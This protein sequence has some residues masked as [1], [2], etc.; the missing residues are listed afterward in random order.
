MTNS[1]RSTLRLRLRG[2]SYPD[3]EIPLA[4]LAAIADRAQQLATRLARAE[5]G[6]G[7]P[8]RSPNRLAEGVR[9]MF[10]GIEPGSTQLLIAGPPRDPQFDLG[11]LSEEAIERA[12]AQLVD[13]LDA[14]AAGTPLPAGYDDLSRRGLAEWLE[15]LAQAAPEVEVEGR[16]GARAPKTVRLDPASASAHLREPPAPPAPPP[17]VAVEGVLYAVN[18][19][20]GRYR[21]EDD[22][23]SS[24]DL[25]TSLFTTE[26]VAPLLG[27]RVAAGGAAKYD[28]S[29]KLKEIDAT[30]IAPAPDIPGLDP[31]RFWR[32]VELDELL[33][34]ATPLESIDELT[35]PGLTVEEGDAFLRAIRE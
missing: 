12:F 11:P 15:A 1:E 3:G 9:L 23:G 14:A 10:V 27:Q 35:I 16:V 8:G 22:M 26:Q 25:V 4:N 31:S 24:I 13:G 2:A 30:T 32:N 19:R 34:D 7:G 17:S 33:R 18:L 29:G 28:D 21:I 6:R 5:E 20:T